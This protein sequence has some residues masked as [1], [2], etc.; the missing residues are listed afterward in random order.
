MESEQKIKN[1]AQRFADDLV[2]D[3]TGTSQE[4]ILK[5]RKLKAQQAWINMNKE[6]LDRME[7]HKNGL[8]RILVYVS[9]LN[10]ILNLLILLL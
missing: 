4:D 5:F 9:L 8:L 6:T 2:K 10:F 7:K 3:A 1:D